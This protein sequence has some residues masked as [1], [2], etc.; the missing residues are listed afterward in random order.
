MSPLHT[1][2]I[3]EF[4]PSVIKGCAWKQFAGHCLLTTV[5]TISCLEVVWL[6]SVS[7]CHILSA[8]RGCESQNGPPLNDTSAVEGEARAKGHS[9]GPSA[10][11]PN[12]GTGVPQPEANW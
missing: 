10:E 9:I 6:P 3:L 8:A 7:E 4:S 5:L 1:V 12:D 11:F 2:T